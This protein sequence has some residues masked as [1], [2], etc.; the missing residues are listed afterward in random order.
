MEQFYIGQ[1]FMDEY[2][3]E[4]AVWCNENMECFIDEVD[5]VNGK[6]V[7]EIKQIPE[8][9]DEQLKA[10]EVEKIKAELNQI[11][12]KSIRAIRAGD[13]EYVKQYEDMAKVLRAKLGDLI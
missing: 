1:T 10:I 13:M 8:P 12:L 6:R 7:F 9:T 4:A 2:P 5:S 3:F 11:D